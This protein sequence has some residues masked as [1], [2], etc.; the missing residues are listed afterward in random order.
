MEKQ[1]NVSS[2]VVQALLET[3]EFRRCQHQA[4]RTVPTRRF[5]QLQQD[6]SYVVFGSHISIPFHLSAAVSPCHL[7]LTYQ[8][9]DITRSRSSR[10]KL[11]RDGLCPFGTTHEDVS[12]D[13]FLS[14]AFIVRTAYFGAFSY[15]RM[16]PTKYW[17]NVRLSTSRCC[18][19]IVQPR[20]SS[21][22][23]LA[24]VAH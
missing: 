7:D 1:P 15:T 9:I 6:I 19:V 17:N 23:K 3:G 16:P 12:D 11:S 18:A 2:W 13:M 22:F 4:R 14:G 20:Y 10:M 21:S 24:P 5:L 8:S